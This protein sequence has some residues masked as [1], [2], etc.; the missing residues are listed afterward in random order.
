MKSFFKLIIMRLFNNEI[1]ISID[2][3]DGSDNVDILIGIHVIEGECE[4]CAEPMV[5]IQIGLLIFT[6]TITVEKPH[7]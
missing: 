6:I 1:N 4:C 5:G 3:P 2:L 7:V